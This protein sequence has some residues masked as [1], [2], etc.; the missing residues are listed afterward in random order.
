MLSECASPERSII[1]ITHYFE[2]LESI[3]V[4]QVIVMR[5]GVIERYGGAELARE[6]RENGYNENLS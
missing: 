3:P 1:I 5:D 4:D 2:I 6:I